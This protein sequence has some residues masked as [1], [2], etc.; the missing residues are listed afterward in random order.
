MYFFGHMTHFCSRLTTRKK[1]AGKII[2]I[3]IQAKFLSHD[4]LIGQ[5]LIQA[6]HYKVKN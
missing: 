3:K 5:V 2:H 1:V 4:K 6:V